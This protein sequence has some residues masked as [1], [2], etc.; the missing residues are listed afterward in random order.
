MMMLLK[1][2]GIKYF[3]S[4]NHTILMDAYSRSGFILYPTSFSETGCIT[5][6]KAMSCGSIPITSRLLS[7]VLPELTNGYDHGPINGLNIDNVNKYGNKYDDSDIYEWIKTYWTST[8]I[9]AYKIDMNVKKSNN[10]PGLYDKRQEMKKYAKTAFSWKN[11][12]NILSSNF[13]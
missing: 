3:G 5:L 8:V 4:V 11:S 12:A 2:D 6:M 7:S 1:Q 9:D 10:K 13:Y